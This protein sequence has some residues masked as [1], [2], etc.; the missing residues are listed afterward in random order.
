MMEIEECK[1][2]KDN[3]IKEIMEIFK[4]EKEN[5]K[6]KMHENEQKIKD[7]EHNKS[8]LFLEHEKERAKWALERDHLI[9]QKNEAQDIVDSLEKRKET[10]VRENEKLKATRGRISS[11]KF[12]SLAAVN[13]SYMTGILSSNISFDEVT[14]EVKTNT[15]SSPGSSS[16][17]L[18]TLPLRFKNYEG[19]KAF[20]NYMG[21]IARKPRRHIDENSRS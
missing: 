18:S 3:K 11:S 19:S 1:Q 12:D 13:K 10:L 15:C 9:S 4:A 17:D 6:S 16:H 21:E 2:Q 8:Q 5:F 7:L 20:G 14:K